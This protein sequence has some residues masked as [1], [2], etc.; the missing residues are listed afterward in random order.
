MDQQNSES[1]IS[2]HDNDMNEASASTENVSKTRM[3]WPVRFSTIIAVFNLVL[4]IPFGVWYVQ[5]L[6]SENEQVEA[7]KRELE[8]YSEQL[9]TELSASVPNLSE[10][11]KSQELGLQRLSGIVKQLENK[12]R[13]VEMMSKAYQSTVLW[14]L[15]DL[16][17]QIHG[18]PLDVSTKQESLAYLRQLRDTVSSSDLGP[19]SQEIIAALDQDVIS[20]NNARTV[21]R[22]AIETLI[23]RLIE[24]SSHMELSNAGPAV[25][26]SFAVDNASINSEWSLLI[27]L[28]QEIKSLI[29]VRQV[30][31]SSGTLDINYFLRETL[32]L[33]LLETMYLVRANDIS[34]AAI[35]FE[36]IQLYI[37]TNFDLDGAETRAALA[38]MGD[39]KSMTDVTASNLSATLL[40]LE[41]YFLNMTSD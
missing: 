34:R 29:K 18:A 15:R 24:F 27:N 16:L 23:E 36:E 38:M 28:W 11:L 12:K 33:K 14:H 7:N 2:E 35:R 21:N 32:R 10:T 8:K 31:E 37:N 5:V 25:D 22:A 4:V 39:V 19:K 1:K 17:T 20:L 40:L 3:S 6:M 26:A 13:P 30:D 41:D 9:Q